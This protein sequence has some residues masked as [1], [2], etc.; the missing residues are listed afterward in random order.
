MLSKMFDP[1]SDEVTWT[2]GNYMMRFFIAF[3][4]TKH[5]IQVIILGRMRWPWHVTRVGER[6]CAYTVLMGKP[7]R[8]SALRRPGHRWDDM[9]ADL[10]DSRAWIGFLWLRI[11]LSG[12]LM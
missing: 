8:N 12:W 9:K 10:K 6:R 7:T 11:G 2:E 4:L 3:N 1:R 5:I